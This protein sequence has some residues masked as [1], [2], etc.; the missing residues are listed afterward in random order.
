M[1]RSLDI[2][3][4]DVKRINHYQ[5]LDLPI[6]LDDAFEFVV[7]YSNDVEIV[8]VVNERR[9]QQPVNVDDDLE[10]LFQMLLN[11]LPTELDDAME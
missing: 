10:L 6:K 1:F 7:V 2:I 9:P 3:Q 8:D 11:K 4:S 5:L